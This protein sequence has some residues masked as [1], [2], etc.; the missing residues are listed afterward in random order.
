MAAARFLHG[1]LSGSFSVIAFLAVTALALP[2]VGTAP[3]FAL[4]L[5]AALGGQLALRRRGSSDP[6][7]IA[8]TPLPGSGG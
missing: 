4:A 3:G 1:V 2:A 5:V 6:V 8:S 7:G